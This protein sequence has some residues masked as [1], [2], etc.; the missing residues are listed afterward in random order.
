MEGANWNITLFGIHLQ[1][2]QNN[3][4][5]ASPEAAA[6]KK[7]GTRSGGARLPSGVAA[8][9]HRCETS[10][11]WQREAAAAALGDPTASQQ[12]ARRQP[13]RGARE[14]VTQRNNSSSWRSKYP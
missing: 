5:L 14:Q 4:I 2:Q 8:E 3:R 11:S 12:V 1:E 7:G 9:L 10:S 6:A 13:G